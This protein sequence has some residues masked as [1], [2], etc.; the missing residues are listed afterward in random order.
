MEGE[1]IKVSE[2][3]SATEITGENAVSKDYNG[4][5]YTVSNTPED[6]RGKCLELAAMNYYKSG[7]GKDLL[8]LS[9]SGMSSASSSS[10]SYKE[11][12]LSDIINTY[13]IVN[14]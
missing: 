13:R 8:F 1:R 11:L 7:K 9:S 12:D 2:I 10:A 5:S 3:V 14:V 6:L 4:I